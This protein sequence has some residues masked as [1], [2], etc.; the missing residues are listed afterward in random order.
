MLVEAS[1]LSTQSHV[2]CFN[3]VKKYITK[4]I[5]PFNYEMR[6]SISKQIILFYFRYLTRDF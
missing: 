1:P 5:I 4:I 6:F 2:N 3:S